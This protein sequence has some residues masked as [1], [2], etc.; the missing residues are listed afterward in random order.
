TWVVSYQLYLGFTVTEVVY[1]LL[2]QAFP[3]VGEWRPWLLVGVAVALA[4][5]LVLAERAVLWVLLAS[6]VAQAVV[7]IVL[8]AAVLN[9]HLWPW[10][11]FTVGGHPASDASGTG[12]P[13]LAV[14]CGSLPLIPG[15]WR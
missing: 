2:P 8:A 15:R 7:M 1:D 6:V 12:N 3:G 11:A 14:G 5:A 9:G 4:A 10:D 13:P